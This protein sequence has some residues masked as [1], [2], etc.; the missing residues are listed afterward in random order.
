MTFREREYFCGLCRVATAAWRWD[1]D[2]T[3]P[4]PVCGVA[5]AE[6]THEP[7]HAHAV[8]GDDI[9]G[10]LEIRHA[11]CHDDGTPRRFYSKSAIREAARKAG[12]T[13]DGETPKSTKHREV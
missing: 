4:C 5:M 6:V 11:I 10:G 12:W 7:S 2:Q 1:T 3:P 13:I 9:P 8:I